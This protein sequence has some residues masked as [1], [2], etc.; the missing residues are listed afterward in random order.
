MIIYQFLFPDREG[1]ILPKGEGD[2]LMVSGF[3]ACEFGLNIQITE[4][5]LSK[6]NNQW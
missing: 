5:E 1:R 6:V 4:E 3:I 2:G